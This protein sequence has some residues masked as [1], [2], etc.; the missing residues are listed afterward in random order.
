MWL[1]VIGVICVAALL[2]RRVEVG[3]Q[4]TRTCLCTLLI[5]FL[6][7]SRTLEVYHVLG[8]A[9]PLQLICSLLEQRVQLPALRPTCVEI[10]I[11]NEGV[12]PRDEGRGGAVL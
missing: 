4:A 1:C 6:E 12:P 11:V 7:D 10:F 2:H 5:S 3:L 8:P 9:P